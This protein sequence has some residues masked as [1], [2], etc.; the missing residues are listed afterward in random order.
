MDVHSTASRIHVD[1]LVL[2]VRAVS[3]FNSHPSHVSHPNRSSQPSVASSR[4]SSTSFRFPNTLPSLSVAVDIQL[5]QV[6]GG[7]DPLQR[8]CYLNLV[9]LMIVSF[10]FHFEA[11]VALPTL[12]NNRHILRCIH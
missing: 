10:V 7:C 4:S 1:A 2:D 11:T 8:S 5:P 9:D 6:H 12:A 3:Y